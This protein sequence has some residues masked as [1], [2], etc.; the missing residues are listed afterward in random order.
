[1]EEIQ[2]ATMR[3]TDQY[4]HAGDDN[5]SFCSFR[6]WERSETMSEWGNHFVVVVVRREPGKIN[7][8]WKAAAADVV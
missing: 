8:Y 1:M 5:K 4:S 3:S 7:N 2:F 6:F